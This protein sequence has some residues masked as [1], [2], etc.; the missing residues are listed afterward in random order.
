[1]KLTSEAIRFSITGKLPE[2]EKRKRLI[3]RWWKCL[4]MVVLGTV[5]VVGV[6]ATM[7]Q[8]WLLSMT[9]REVW[10]DLYYLMW[11]GR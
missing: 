8:A 6:L 1:M 3:W 5:F 2:P 4:P 10:M 11:A 7:L 9:P